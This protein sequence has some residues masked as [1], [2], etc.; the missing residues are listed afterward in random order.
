[1]RFVHFTD[2]DVV[3]HDLVSRIVRAYD[4]AGRDGK[5]SRA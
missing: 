3:R 2:R 4:R 1:V 5:E